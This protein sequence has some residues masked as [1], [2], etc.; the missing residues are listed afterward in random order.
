MK[1]FLILLAPVALAACSTSATPHYD[2]LFG[3]AVRQARVQQTLD[4][5]AGRRA[6]PVPG[7]DGR[8]AEEGMKN[9]HDSFKT[10]P[11]VVN[12]INLGGS[13][14]GGSPAQ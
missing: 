13:S 3:D 1:R 4:P 14:S 6:M 11:P 2:L 7:L 8:A 9:Y 5:E 10:P 12:V